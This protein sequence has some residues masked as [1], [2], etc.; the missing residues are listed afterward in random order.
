[1]KKFLCFV[2]LSLAFVGA[3]FTQ[4]SQSVQSA[5]DLYRQ[6]E[7]SFY[8]RDYPQA[9]DLLEQAAAQKHVEAP[10]LLGIVYFEKWRA[11]H[12]PDDQTQ[13]IKWLEKAA[14]NG[15]ED[16][17]RFLV[18]IYFYGIED[19][20]ENVNKGMD[21]LKRAAAKDSIPAIHRLASFYE[22]GEFV[23]QD[24]PKARQLYEKAANLGD[25][26]S[27]ATLAHI[28]EMGNGVAQDY[29]KARQWYE[30]AAKLDYGL[31]YLYLGKMYAN[32][33]GIPANDA[34]ATAL[35][36]KYIESFKEN[37]RAQETY[38]VGSWYRSGRNT[39]D[40]PS[41]Q[42]QAKAW[43]WFEKSA[44]LG[45]SSAHYLL[46]QRYF[47]GDGVAQDYVK[48]AQWFEKAVELGYWQY[49][50]YPQLM[51]AKMYFEGLGVEQNNFKVRALLEEHNVCF[52]ELSGYS[53]PIE[54]ESIYRLGYLYANGLGAQQ[55]FSK[56]RQCLKNACEQGRYEQACKE[57]KVLDDKE[58][59]E[60]SH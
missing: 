9:I 33:L 10:Y 60:F 55:D 18:D 8:S 51:L 35:F 22:R 54:V 36:E 28:Y 42:D 32:G 20:P 7:L 6:G 53:K 19:M 56:A 25:G 26:E 24:L 45:D 38:N 5:Q 14:N 12:A 30:K 11:N 40:T 34:K 59:V 16:A 3:G 58:S 44:D 1:M 43:Q 47:Q 17:L 4:S 27:A 49:G 39:G 31:A 46:G 52:Y 57:L 23:P 41:E 37:E 48:A 21:L 29:V 13:V 50:E 2:F 15:H